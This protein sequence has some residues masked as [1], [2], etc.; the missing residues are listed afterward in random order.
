M[1]YGRTARIAS[2]TLSASGRRPA[3]RAAARA[4]SRRRAP[5]DRAPVPPRLTGSCASSEQRDVAPASS[6]RVRRRR[7]QPHGFDHRRSRSPRRTPVGSSPCSCTAPSRTVRRRAFA[8]RR[9]VHEDADR[10]HERRQRCAR[11]RAPGTGRSQRGLSGQKTKPIAAPRARRRAAASSAVVMP[12][13]F[14]SITA[15]LAAEPARPTS[16]RSA[17][18]G[19]AAVMNARRS[20]TRGSRAPRAARG[21]RRLESAL[22]HRD[23]VRRQ[24]ARPARPTRRGRRQ[25]TQVAVVDADRSRAPASIARSQLRLVVHFDERVEAELAARAMQRRTAPAWS[26]AATISSTASAPAARA[27]SSWY[28]STM[29]SLRSSGRSHARREPRADARARRRR[30]SAR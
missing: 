28:S 6:P 29:K 22:A 13:I 27:S 17:S 18:P 30:T 21:R 19:S 23:D 7:P 25:R 16:A 11:S 26:S 20:E 14:T 8:F 9:L 10:R 15:P 5:V 3:A 4:M 1:P 24:H 2:A 12:Q